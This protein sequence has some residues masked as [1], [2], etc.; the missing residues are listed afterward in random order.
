MQYRHKI[1]RWGTLLVFMLASSA[2][3]AGPLVLQK[4]RFWNAPDH[5]RVVFDITNPADYRLFTLENPN[6]VV[7]DIQ[8][9]DWKSGQRPAIENSG[10]VKNLR[11]ARQKDRTLRLVLDTDRK[12]KPKSFLLKPNE[13]YGHRLVVDLY[14]Q[15]EGPVKAVKSVRQY[16][17]QFKDVVIAI[18]AG[19]GGEDPG[20][21]GARGSKEKHITLAVAKKLAAIINKQPGMKAILIR[22]GD[23]YLGLRKRMAKARKHRADVFVSLHADAFHKS[24]VNGSSVYILSEGGA[25]SEAAR[26]LAQ[27][28]NDADLVGGVSL[29]DKDDL[30]KSVLLDLSQT[31]T[32]EASADLA[33]TTLRQLKGVGKVH[34]RHVERAGFAVLKSPD[35]PSILI[36]L[37]FISNPTEEKN[38][39]S[40]NHQ[41]KIARAILAGLKSYLHKRP[42]DNTL[43]AARTHT[44]KRGDTLSQLAQ[45]YQTSSRQLRSA[46]G[47]SGDALRIGQV[48]RIPLRGS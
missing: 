19:H 37:A 34:R 17:G 14:Q 33:R 10:Y 38:L 41:Q 15:Q 32:I 22:Q 48:L 20:A 18:D 6:R 45:T 47:L 29:D 36:E 1:T 35:I 43:F 31:A 9:A 25:S 44:I 42:P 5:T 40:K 7:I 3:F 13:Q 23:Y 2:V 26:W 21:S 28:A 11:S 16:R 39:N 46:N 30:L 4:V 27:K 12:I 24:Y 8:Q